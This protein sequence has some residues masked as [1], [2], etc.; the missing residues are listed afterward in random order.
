[1]GI[2]E[3]HVTRWAAPHRGHRRRGDALYMVI[4]GQAV[5]D[6]YQ[7]TAIGADAVELKDLVTGGYRRLRCC[8]ESRS[9]SRAQVP[10]LHSRTRDGVTTA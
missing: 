10:S 8:A 7:V 3:E 2:A 4:A 6:R 9:K 1:M 5:A